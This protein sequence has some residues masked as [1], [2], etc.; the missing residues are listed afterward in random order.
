MGNTWPTPAPSA[1]YVMK[2]VAPEA[3]GS[4]ARDST[5]DSEVMEKDRTNVYEMTEEGDTGTPTTPTPTTY[6][7]TP[8]P[9]TPTTY[10]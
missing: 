4:E 3:R 9:P 5:S 2:V 10:T 8:G 7:W 6:I 1:G